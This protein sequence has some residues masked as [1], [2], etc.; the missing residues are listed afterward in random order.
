MFLLVSRWETATQHG[1]FEAWARTYASAIENTLD[2]YI[3]ALLFL[4][5]AFDISPAPV[6]RQQ[7]KAITTSI[8]PRYPGIQA[9]GWDPLVKH[10]DREQIEAAARADGY[11]S[12]EITERGA[13]NHMVRASIRDEYV[14]VYFMHPLKNN[15]AAFGF[16][17]AS[18]PTRRETIETGFL[19]GSLRATS[20]IKLVQESGD[21]YGLLT[22]LPIYHQNTALDTPENRWAHRK[23][24]VV[25][26]LRIGDAVE[27]ALK[28]LTDIGIHMTLRDLSAPKPS[29]L[30]Y[31][32]PD[33][34]TKE[35]NETD[36]P[37]TDFSW[38]HTFR[39]TD[40]QWELTL[41]PSQTFYESRKTWQAWT[42]LFGSLLL[43]GLIVTKSR[44]EEI[45]TAD[46]ERR[47]QQQEKTEAQ[48]DETITKL[49][50]AITEVESLKG[51]LPLCSFCKK[52][53]NDEGYWE[54]VEVY[55]H[56]H[57]KADVS[58]SICPTCMTEHY[59]EYMDDAPP[60]TPPAESS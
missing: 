21:Q 57:S 13:S 37:H 4:G 11:S 49:Q 6:T 55:I 32:R 42:I 60:T 14:P 12:Y 20:R 58:H 22:L 8:L 31:H 9:F 16:D 43:T 40:R 5:D 19:T 15:E 18:D 44:Q 27:E 52:I 10:A 53:R 1:E 46:I 47:M 33:A 29:R 48:R 35:A 25:E 51:I 24:F 41:S 59:S 56:K 3:G 30:L 17:I 7:F 54:Q 23:G 34:R 2:E 45:Y 36:D 38:T 50:Q 39:Y 26:V 28:G